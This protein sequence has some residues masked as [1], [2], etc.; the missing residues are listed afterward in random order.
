MTESAYVLIQLGYTTFGEGET[1]E[2]AREDARQ[3]LDTPS[4]ADDVEVRHSKLAVIR[5][6]V[7]GDLVIVPRAVADDLGI[8]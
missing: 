1:A 5:N 2:A 4:D 8:Y 3:G 6:H 7:D